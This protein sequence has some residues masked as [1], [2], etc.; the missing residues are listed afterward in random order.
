MEEIPVGATDQIYIPFDQQVAASQEY[1]KTAF[2]LH[3]MIVNGIDSWLLAIASASIAAL[4]FSAETRQAI[5]EKHEERLATITIGLFVATIFLALISKAIA[6]ILTALACRRGKRVAEKQMHEFIQV[7]QKP[8]KVF[9]AWYF[10]T[11]FG[12]FSFISLLAGVGMAGLLAARL[13]K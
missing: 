2:E 3:L 10:H 7:M 1:H 5:T 8:S 9:W 12:I 11:G 6:W 4:L 13:L